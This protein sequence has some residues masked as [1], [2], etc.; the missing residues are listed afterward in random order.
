MPTDEPPVGIQ[1][2]LEGIQ[3][4]SG[5]G[6]LACD[7]CNCRIHADED[8]TMF[9]ARSAETPWMAR[10]FACMECEDTIVGMPTKGMDEV[11]VQVTVEE[12]PGYGR[13]LWV[14]FETA[15]VLDR[16]PPTE[17]SRTTIEEVEAGIEASV[18]PGADRETACDDVH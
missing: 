16:E 3:A 9:A 5:Q 1:A 2:Q 7:W 11:I 10:S 18:P 15:E 14:S 12:Q 6:V 8:V 17:G 4:G 13:K